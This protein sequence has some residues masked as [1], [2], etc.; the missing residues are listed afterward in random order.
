M[1]LVGKRF[2]RW[3][4]KELGEPYYP[5]NSKYA[6]KR[7]NCVCDCGTIKVVEGSS[8]SG[9]KTKSC[10]CLRKEIVTTHGHS[11]HPLYSVWQGMNHRCS[12]STHVS[13][14]DYGG[15]GIIVCNEWSGIPTGLLQFIGDMKES[16]MSGL[17]LD[18]IDVNGNYCKENC[19][20]ATP[21]EQAINR[22]PI[23][24]NFDAHLITFSGKT[25]CLSQWADKTGINSAAICH[26]LSRLGWSVEKTLTTPVYVRKIHITV[27]TIEYSMK[28]VFKHKTH[29][30]RAAKR[31]NKTTEQ[32]C[33]DIFH[34]IAEVGVYTNGERIVICSIEDCSKNL[35]KYTLNDSF[36]EVLYHKADA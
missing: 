12:D 32:F 34:G 6:R 14:K 5:P 27:N 29:I 25:M 17:E 15:R 2:G 35:N 23:G 20:W 4:V 10:G 31:L 22:R 11:A 7:Y 36:K 28:D 8:L 19:T 30:S 9:G 33:A 3:L 13:Y 18:R 24:T 1:S 16:Y 26:R 21:S